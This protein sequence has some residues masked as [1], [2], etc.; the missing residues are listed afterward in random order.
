MRRREHFFFVYHKG[1]RSLARGQRN[2]SNAWCVAHTSTFARGSFLCG[3][4]G[5]N[6]NY[7]LG[8]GS[9]ILSVI[10]TLNVRIC[11]PTDPNA[12]Y[13]FDTITNSFEA[14]TGAVDAFED[15][16]VVI[17]RLLRLD[18]PCAQSAV[19]ACVH[20]LDNSGTVFAF[21]TVCRGLGFDNPNSDLACN[22]H[23]ISS[24]SFT[25]S[26]EHD[27]AGVCELGAEQYK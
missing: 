2:R 22:V 25:D 1:T 14:A 11:G 15:D 9:S 21:C 12:E 7:S 13:G 3:Y 24:D 23:S 8:I 26:V 20:G 19:N 16:R 10:S 5:S 4:D 27:E 6:L 17:T 18:M